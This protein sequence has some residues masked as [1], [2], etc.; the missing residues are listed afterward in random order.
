MATT[1]KKTKP[2]TR[3]WHDVHVKFKR[4]TELK[5]RL[6]SSFEDKLAPLCDLEC[7]YMETISKRWLESE[8]DIEAMYKT[9]KN[10][11]EITL[12]CDGTLPDVN[13]NGRKRKSSESHE[14]P[15]NK[16]KS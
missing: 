1:D 11:H 12:W 3:I 9:F 2:V 7:G 10:G 4:V 5:D 14:E 8:G 6:V 13:K 16:R 15:A